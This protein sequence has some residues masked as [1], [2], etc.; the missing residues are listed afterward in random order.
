[1]F[2]I[3]GSSSVEVVKSVSY[4]PPKAIISHNNKGLVFAEA[5][6]GVDGEAITRLEVVELREIFLLSINNFLV[7]GGFH[8]FGVCKCK[9]YWVRGEGCKE[10]GGHVHEAT[11]GEHDKVVIQGISSVIVRVAAEQIG[12]I[13]FTRFMMELEIVLYELDLPSGST[14]S[15]FMGLSPICEVLV[16]G[17]NNDG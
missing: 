9:F 11:E 12:F 2:K 5:I 10:V 1:V 4:P 3:P 7:E 17:P 13:A 6:L 15:N 16:V 14:G 8:I